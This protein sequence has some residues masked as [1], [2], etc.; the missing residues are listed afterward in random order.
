MNCLG[1]PDTRHG[2]D[3]CGCW[4]RMLGTPYYPKTNIIY[5]ATHKAA[6]ALLEALEETHAGLSLVHGHPPQLACGSAEDTCPQRVALIQEAKGE[7]ADVPT[8]SL[9]EG[10]LSP[11]SEYYVFPPEHPGNVCGPSRDDSPGDTGASGSPLESLEAIGA[12]MQS[13]IAVI[14]GLLAEM[15]AEN[16]A[17]L[18]RSENWGQL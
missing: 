5:C 16:E 7:R 17:L 10:V 14:Q 11:L 3:G 1:C 18:E 12:K 6:F 2:H 8:S 13:Q 9:Q 4:V 15:Q